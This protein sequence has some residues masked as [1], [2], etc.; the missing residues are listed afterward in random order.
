MDNVYKDISIAFAP[1]SVKR[2]LRLFLD[3]TGAMARFERNRKKM[4]SAKKIENIL[5]TEIEDLVNAPPSLF[6]AF[7]GAESTE[8]IEITERMSSNSGNAIE[9][10]WRAGLKGNAIQDLEKAEYYISR[11]IERLKNV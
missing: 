1:D 8:I 3:A 10:I 5:G 6:G 9:H 11:E 4:K 2:Q 7:A